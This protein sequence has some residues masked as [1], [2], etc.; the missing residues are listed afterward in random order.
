MTEEKT[1]G[2][3]HI[4]GLAALIQI[5][6]DDMYL[7]DAGNRYRDFFALD[8]E[9]VGQSVLIGLSDIE[10]R[11]LCSGL[12]AKAKR[13]EAFSYSR[14][15]ICNNRGICWLR[16]QASFLENRDGF[17]S[18]VAVMTDVTDDVLTEIQMEKAAESVEQANREMDFIINMLDEGIAKVGNKEG[19][20]VLYANSAFYR[21]IGYTRDQFESVCGNSLQNLDVSGVYEADKT[22]KG[23]W[24]KYRES[25]KGSEKQFHV[26]YMRTGQPPDNGA[27]FYLILSDIDRIQEKNLELEKMM[28]YQSL[29]DRYSPAATLIRSATTL[30]PLYISKNAVNNFDYSQDE[31]FSYVDGKKQLIVHPDDY[32]DI[33]VPVSEING[34]YDYQKEFRVKRKDGTYVWC[35]EK[36]CLERREWKEPVYI[37]SFMNI[38]ELKKTQEQVRIREDEYKIMV[39]HSGKMVYRYH[40]KDETLDMPLKTEYLSGLMEP[41]V[42]ASENIIN[43][44]FIAPESEEELK[45]FCEG[46]NKGDGEGKVRVK[47][48]LNEE[49]YGWYQGEYSTIYDNDGQ[50]DSVVITVEDITGRMKTDTELRL[51][52]QEMAAITT[53]HPDD[54]ILEY[55]VKSRRAA[56]KKNT[57]EEFGIPEIIEDMPSG[58]IDMGIV[59]SESVQDYAEVFHDIQQGSASGSNV[60]RKKS[61]E[62]GWIHYRICYKTV[63]GQDGKPDYAILSFRNIEEQ[64]LNG[65]SRAIMHELENMMHESRYGVLSS[66][67]VENRVE[68]ARGGLFRLDT[69]NNQADD[70]DTVI[71]ELARIWIC[72]DDNGHWREFNNRNWLMFMYDSGTRWISR[73]YRLSGTG[74]DGEWVREMVMLFTDP[75]SNYIHAYCMFHI[76]SVPGRGDEISCGSTPDILTPFTPGVPQNTYREPGARIWNR[77]GMDWMQ[78]LPKEEKNIADTSRPSIFIR[79]FGYFDVFINGKVLD[80][81]SKKCKELL[82]VL[83]DRNGGI[84]TTEEAISILWE[85][86]PMDKSTQNRYRQIVMRLKH[87]LAEA[88]I[89]DIVVSKRGGK[90]VDK[91]RFDCDFYLFLQGNEKYRS[92]FHYIYMANYS[93]G[94]STLAILSAM[95]KIT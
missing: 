50:P 31:I 18:Y 67:I 16:G 33:I 77:N 19:Y 3:N 26:K 39:R 9:S 23:G 75:Y 12:Y 13:K 32:R 88:G 66:I 53:F 27:A 21:M 52:K 4:P 68:E 44:G 86:E 95:K 55:D 48:R 11:T 5:H 89:E 42:S 90:C 38:N 87:I 2:L 69:V 64:Y 14:K 1:I 10:R 62:H 35:C 29:V 41:I 60:I 80:F 34:N 57:A 72:E 70:F 59:A 92:I 54:L 49:G 20:P 6:E 74:E 94:E 45:R 91:T 79:T 65:M 85:N 25:G 43:A 83:V 30:E 36:T 51:L 8:S 81:P 84:C 82:A 47:C 15:A 24:W 58:I 37:S 71:N 28:Y 17:P 93:W 46:I 40:V 63:F 61:K 76:L 73:D 7:L 56:V 78:D 22:G